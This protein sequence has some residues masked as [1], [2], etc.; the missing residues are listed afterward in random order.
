MKRNIS[1][2]DLWG[3]KKTLLLARCSYAWRCR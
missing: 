3:R 1:L 2:S